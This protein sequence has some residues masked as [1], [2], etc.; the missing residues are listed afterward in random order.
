VE[1]DKA[2]NKMIAK[3][4]S[5]KNSKENVM[6]KSNLIT[7]DLE[8]GGYS[9]DVGDETKTDNDLEKLIN[10]IAHGDNIDNSEVE[11]SARDSVTISKDK[12]IISL[13]GNAKVFHNKTILSGTKIVYNKNNSSVMVNNATMMSGGN[14]AIKADSINFN[15]KTSKAKLY[16]ADLNR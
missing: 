8:K 7:F 10:S 11:Y 12:S 13:F 4:A 3:N 15:L 2:N 5:L 16:G 1:L 9:I 6:V 14:K